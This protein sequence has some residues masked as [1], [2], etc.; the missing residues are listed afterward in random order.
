MHLARGLLALEVPDAGP[1]PWT[2]M[3]CGGTQPTEALGREG[4]GGREGGVGVG[5]E[6]GDGG[7][8]TVRPGAWP[9]RPDT[10]YRWRQRGRGVREGERHGGGTAHAQGGRSRGKRPPPLPCKGRGGPDS[11]LSACFFSL[12]KDRGGTRSWIPSRCLSL[13][14]ILLPSLSLFPSFIPPRS[15]RYHSSHSRTRHGS[16]PRRLKSP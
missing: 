7:E 16:S 9:R 5:G 8:K 2:T 1:L 12:R 13:I 15:P 11:A 10:D 6:E 4:G 3:V 14:S